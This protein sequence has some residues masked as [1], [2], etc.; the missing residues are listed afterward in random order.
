LLGANEFHRPAN[1]MR[2]HR[3]HFDTASLDP[4]L[5]HPS[6]LSSRSSQLLAFLLAVHLAAPASACDLGLAHATFFS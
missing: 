6:N 4:T 5:S 3:H 2:F 1:W